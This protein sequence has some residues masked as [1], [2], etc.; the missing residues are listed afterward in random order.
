MYIA[1]IQRWWLFRNATLALRTYYSPVR[2][3]KRESR[4]LNG[5]RQRPKLFDKGRKSDAVRS[6]KEKGN[7]SVNLQLGTLTCTVSEN[8]KKNIVAMSMKMIF[9]NHSFNFF[10]FWLVS[11][12]F[13]ASN[14]RIQHLFHL[15]RLL[16]S[17]MMSFLF[18]RVNP[19]HLYVNPHTQKIV[20]LYEFTWG[21][22]L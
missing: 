4:D 21:R 17:D 12:I 3:W 16:D 1:P 13:P 6:M 11:A 14:P 9:H 19:L 15:H 5:R 22:N 10:Y 20:M 7:K 2:K 18:A 8:H